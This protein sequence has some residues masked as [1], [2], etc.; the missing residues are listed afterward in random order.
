MES[1]RSLGSATGSK[2]RLAEGGQIRRDVIDEHLFVEALALT[3]FEITYQEPS[4][5]N[6]EKIVLLMEKLNHSEG[7]QIV[8]K[9][10]GKPRFLSQQGGDPSDLLYF[11]RLSHPEYFSGSQYQFRSQPGAGARASNRAAQ[12]MDELMNQGYGGGA[13]PRAGTGLGPGRDAVRSSGRV[14]GSGL[15]RYRERGASSN[16]DALVGGTSGRE[17]ESLGPEAQFDQMF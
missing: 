17:Y 6:A 4:P 10:I 16:F 8:Q 5:T 7:P 11:I 14:A 2:A 1:R 13:R 9:A 3:A 15:G 12:E